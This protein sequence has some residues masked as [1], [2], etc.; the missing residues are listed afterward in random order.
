MD[1]AALKET[2]GSTKKTGR[3]QDPPLQKQQY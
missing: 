1:V 2:K 3:A